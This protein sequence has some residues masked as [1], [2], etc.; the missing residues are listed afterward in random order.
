MRSRPQPSFARAFTLVEVVLAIGI[1]SFAGIGMVAVLYNIL[2]NT[3][4][5][6]AR[7]DALRLNGALEDVLQSQSFTN[8][9]QWYQS[10]MPVYAYTFLASAPTGTTNSPTPAPTGS[11]ASA[12]STNNILVPSIRAAGDSHLSGELAMVQGPVYLVTFQLSPA[13]PLSETTNMPSSAAGYTNADVMALTARFY[14]A[15]PPSPTGTIS[16]VSTNKPP[17]HTCT[18]TFNATQQ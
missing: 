5:I 13:N 17:I 7:D 2:T 15:P 3:A 10:Q 9:F 6:A 14:V 16:A 4:S 11:S 1:F 12:G 8:V 18:V